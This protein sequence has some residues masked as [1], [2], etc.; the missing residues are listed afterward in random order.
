[1]SGFQKIQL[2]IAR[3]LQLRRTLCSR[4]RNIEYASGQ[5]SVTK[6]KVVGQQRSALKTITSGEMNLL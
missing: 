4:K 6:Q 3:D 1:M 2:Q 5:S